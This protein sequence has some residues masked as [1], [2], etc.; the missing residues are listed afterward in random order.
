MFASTAMVVSSLSCDSHLLLVGMAS[1]PSLTFA[2]QITLWAVMI[3]I[4]RNKS[5]SRVESRD[6]QTGSS[7]LY[8]VETRISES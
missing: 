5:P 7:E 3:S 2:I 4:K 6:D 1:L 8:Q